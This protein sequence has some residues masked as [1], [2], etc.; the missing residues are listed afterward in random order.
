MYIYPVFD[1]RLRTAAK[2]LL[3][4]RAR[5]SPRASQPE[6]QNESNGHGHA[7]HSTGLYSIPYRMQKHRVGE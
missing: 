7:I 5:R 1:S 4:S 3:S 6:T 2:L